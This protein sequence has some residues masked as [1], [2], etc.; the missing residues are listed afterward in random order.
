MKKV[1]FLGIVLA[2]V[3]GTGADTL[4]QG[5]REVPMAER[6]WCY[7]WWVNG[8]VD[9]E[10]I[11]RDLEAMRRIGLGG[12]HLFT[13]GGIRQDLDLQ[14]NN[15]GNTLYAESAN[16]GFFRPEPG[17]HVVIALRSSF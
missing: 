17:R 5:F 16:A 13:V 12:A 6:P 10:T 2:A 1:V 15:I 14:V 4:E 11:T 3:L 8:N 7:Y 9:T